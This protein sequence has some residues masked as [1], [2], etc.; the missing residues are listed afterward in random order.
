MIPSKMIP[1]QDQQPPKVYRLRQDPKQTVRGKN[2]KTAK[3][4]RH[5]QKNITVVQ[6]HEKNNHSPKLY[7]HIGPCNHRMPVSLD[8][9]N[10]GKGIPEQV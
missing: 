10:L 8:P 1:S 2:W 9:D 7:R 6:N 5:Q 4:K 3:N